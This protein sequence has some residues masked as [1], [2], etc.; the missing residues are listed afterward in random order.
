M[1][2]HDSVL[3][4]GIEDYFAADEPRE[5]YIE[6]RSRRVVV[7]VGCGAKMPYGICHTPGSEHAG[8]PQTAGVAGYWTEEPQEPRYVIVYPNGAVAPL[9]PQQPDPVIP[10]EPFSAA[11]LQLLDS[12]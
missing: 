6:D 10:D 7:C 11:E 2:N 5:P 12:L 3:M 9:P 1:I 4:S 8:C